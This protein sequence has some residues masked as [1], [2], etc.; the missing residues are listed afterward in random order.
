MARIGDLLCPRHRMV[1]LLPYRRDVHLAGRRRAADQTSQHQRQQC[2]WLTGPAPGPR[3]VG[4][5]PG[6]WIGSCRT[7]ASCCH[8]LGPCPTVPSS[9]PL[10]CP[11]LPGGAKTIHEGRRLNT[12]YANSSKLSLT[13]VLV[14][15]S[16]V[17][18]SLGSSFGLIFGLLRAVLGATTRPEPG[19][20]ADAR[21][22]FGPWDELAGRNARGK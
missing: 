15:G 21:G 3:M 11:G 20:A 12:K 8:L 9:Q 17:R 14:D 19:A 22:G 2:G 1:R 5:L 7:S 6:C 10:A 16:C 18:A 4:R 13:G